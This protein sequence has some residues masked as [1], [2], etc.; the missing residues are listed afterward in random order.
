MNQIGAFLM[1]LISIVLPGFGVPSQPVYYGYIE[2]DYFYGAPTT[3]GVLKDLPVAEGD[4][5]EEGDLLFTLKADRQQAALLAAQAQVAAA[6]ANLANIETGSRPEEIKV[7][8]A[9]LDKAKS[10]L[11]L[12]QVTLERSQKL[13]A[14]DLAPQAQV[15]QNKANLEAAKAQVAQLQAQL[16]VARLPGRNAQLLAAEANLD[17]ARAQAA[18]AQ[19]ALDDMSVYAMTSGRV[20]D[21]FYKTGEMVAAGR[22]VLSIVPDKGLT[23]KFYVPETERAH[24]SVGQEVAISCDGCA[25]SLTG[26]ISRFASDPQFTPPIIYSRDERSRLSFLVEAHLQP[27]AH[28]LPG[29]PVSVTVPE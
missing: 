21:V 22:S 24:L 16:D 27:D 26:E 7:I 11:N 15:D 9:S 18:S 25:N 1:G 17:A 29:Q 10:D 20:D 3:S 5:V 28:L 4:H 14:Q 19:S 2:A 8:E 13:A 12:A 23:A 6:E